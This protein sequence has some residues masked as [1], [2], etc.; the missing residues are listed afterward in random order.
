M[1]SGRGI[2]PLVFGIVPTSREGW[3]A[4]AVYAVALWGGMAI[5]NLPLQAMLAI[6]FVTTL[7]MAVV[8]AFT[9]APRN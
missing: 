8:V 4:L 2:S 9:Y 7:A 5:P 3:I 1:G 6:M